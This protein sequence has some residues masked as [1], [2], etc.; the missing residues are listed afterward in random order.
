MLTLEKEK[1]SDRFHWCTWQMVTGNNTVEG[2]YRN[3]QMQLI[4]TFDW[5]IALDN[6]VVIH[7][8]GWF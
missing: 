4:F 7:V 5:Y 1:K 6:C 2:V 3:N 8:V